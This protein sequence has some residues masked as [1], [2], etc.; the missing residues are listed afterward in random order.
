[1]RCNYGSES[2]MMMSKN[3]RKK[4]DEEQ[5]A[6]SKIVRYSKIALLGLLI[7]F[8][9]L[10]VT[11]LFLTSVI[12]K[13]RRDL[14]FV[15]INYGP[16]VAS[17]ISAIPLAI[18]FFLLFKDWGHIKNPNKRVIIFV[19]IYFIMMFLWILYFITVRST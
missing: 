12:M 18:L 2:D 11:L 14:I 7:G 10:F 5:L 17:L 3:K 8:S 15:L 4:V 13:S 16:Y 9:N 19:V 1:M 6:K